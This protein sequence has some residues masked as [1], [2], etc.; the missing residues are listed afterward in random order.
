MV[1]QIRVTATELHEYRSEQMQKKKWG[2]T[3]LYNAFFNEP[4]SQLYQLHAKLN[5]LVMQAY[6][7][8]ENDDILEK[9]L[10]LNQELAAKEKQGESIVGPGRPAE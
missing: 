10:T 9:L 7:F 1:K 8:N 5:K 3:Q 2:I 4:S 6:D